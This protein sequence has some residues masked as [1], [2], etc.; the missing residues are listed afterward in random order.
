MKVSEVW[1]AAAALALLVCPLAKAQAQTPCVTT[2]TNQTCTNSASMAGIIDTATLTLTNTASG[3]VTGGKS[4]VFANTANVANS[5]TI[6]AGGTGIVATT[7][8][9]VTNTG[10]ISG[11]F[12]GISANTANVT[13]SG[14]ISGVFNSISANTANVTNSGTISGRGGAGISANTAKVTNS[15]IISGGS[16]GVLAFNAA[17]VTN[18]GTISGSF[19]GIETITANVTNSGTISGGTYGIAAFLGN[20][21]VTN[22]GTISGIIAL[23]FGGTAN[24]LT[25]LPGSRIIGAINLGGGGSAIKLGESGDSISLGSGDTVNFRGG[26]HN[27]TFDTLTGA[28]VT[29]TTP[30]AVSGNQAVAIDPTSFAANWRSLADFTR[31]VSDAVP[32]FSG[33]TSGGSAPLAFAAPDAPSRFDDAFA[34]IP[35]LSSAYASEAAVFKA[36]T[37]TYADGT[38][39]WA[40]G[41]AGQ[42]IQQQDGVLLRTANLFYG[43]MIGADFAARPD[44]RT[45]VF[46]GGGKTRTSIDLNQG[47]ADS[48][49]LFGGAYARYDIGASFL[50]GA[51]QGGGSRNTTT[52]TVNNNLV[53]GG[54]ENAVASFNGWYVSPELTF[55]HRFAL[56]QLADATYT[57]TPSARVRYLYG[58]FDGYTETGTT[59]PLTVGEQTANTV[60]ERGEVKLTRSVA[61]GPVNQLSTSL[62]GGVLGTQR[63]GSSTVNAALLGQAIPFATPGQANVWGG[64]GGLGLEWRSRNVTLYA[65]AEY[66]ALSDNSNVVS[67]RAGLRV[68][69]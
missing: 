14:T 16:Y 32:V 49:M 15:G 11:G 31:G 67:G 35:G 58:A 20:A 50:H 59:A 1:W 4:G 44:L 10:T 46:L 25:L 61:F 23:Q 22:S 51:I 68:G 40:R 48:D 37:S 45:G 64:F 60:E 2:G 39:V 62:S 41:F 24:T 5:G 42:R 12:D 3:T 56:G 33:G 57:L 54:I 53:T 65:A 26:N 9:N 19:F 43:G 36:P 7:I 17:N 6:S 8:A 18:S 21:S 66:L 27:L 34:A 55:G 29:G 38:T 69:F 63:V 30:F 28:T 47:G 52:R 13:N